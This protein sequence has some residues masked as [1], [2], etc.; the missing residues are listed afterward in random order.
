MWAHAYFGKFYNEKGQEI[1]RIVGRPPTS[2]VCWPL[3]VASQPTK[4]KIGNCWTSGALPI[5][6]QDCGK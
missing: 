5:G 1:K 4:K 3:T 6:F 2:M